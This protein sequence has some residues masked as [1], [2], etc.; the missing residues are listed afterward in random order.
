MSAIAQTKPRLNDRQRDFIAARGEIH[1]IDGQFISIQE[2][3]NLWLGQ[4]E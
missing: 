2:K 3:I 4:S 1:L